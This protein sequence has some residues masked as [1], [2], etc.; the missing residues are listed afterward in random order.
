MP[1]QYMDLLESDETSLQHK[2]RRWSITKINGRLAFNWQEAWLVCWMPKVQLYM[3]LDSNMQV[4]ARAQSLFDCL[5]LATFELDKLEEMASE[6]M[7]AAKELELEVLST[8]EVQEVGAQLQQ[9]AP[10][11]HEKTEPES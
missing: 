5:D 9:N 2:G 10:P 1:K 11:I 4:R 3:A 8:F 6:A 7:K